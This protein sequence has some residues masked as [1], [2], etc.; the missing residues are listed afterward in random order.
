ME[1]KLMLSL[2]EYLERKP[3]YGL[4]V[5]AAFQQLL[6][7]T[8]EQYYENGMLCVQ[9]VVNTYMQ[10]WF[11]KRSWSFDK[12]DHK[13]VE[14]LKEIL[15][16]QFEYMDQNQIW[17]EK[18]NDISYSTAGQ[19]TFT[20]NTNLDESDPYKLIPKNIK[21][22]IKNTGLMNNIVGTER[23]DIARSQYENEFADGY[24]VPDVRW[25]DKANDVMVLDGKNITLAQA[26]QYL[27]S[28]SVSI[29][30][31]DYT[32]ILRKAQCWEY[33]TEALILKS[34]YIK[35]DHFISNKEDLAVAQIKDVKDTWNATNQIVN[36]NSIRIGKVSEI[37]GEMDTKK[38]D[39]S[40]VQDLLSGKASTNLSNVKM[41]ASSVS[42]YL[43]AK[44]DGTLELRTAS[45]DLKVVKWMPD[46]EYFEG[47]FVYI[48]KVV[49]AEQTVLIFM[50]TDKPGNIGK[51]PLEAS[52]KGYWYK[53]AVEF[54]ING[55]ATEEW[56]N[57]N[58]LSLSNPKPILN[59]VDMAGHEVRNASNLLEKS[60][61]SDD[62]VATNSL[63]SS[64][65]VKEQDNKVLEVLNQLAVKAE[66]ALKTMTYTGD[67]LITADGS[68]HVIAELFPDN[69]QEIPNFD[70][71]NRPP[72]DITQNET[73][74][75]YRDNGK[76][77]YCKR[78]NKQVSNNEVLVHNAEMIDVV[79]KRSND[80]K[81][82][83]II[84]S[85]YYYP[86]GGVAGVMFKEENGN[87][88][89]TLTGNIANRINVVVYYTKINETY[90]PDDKPK[91]RAWEIIKPIDLL[92]DMS[93]EK[94]QELINAAKE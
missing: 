36:N 87:I 75:N 93:N 47:T 81:L 74:T 56:V 31:T 94:Y 58:F 5:P 43:V 48:L 29:T 16:M 2:E 25:S 38:A 17:L 80:G 68:V 89:V 52:S 50:A 6:G 83:W 10:N 27:A 84:P 44:P 18:S 41:T 21:L 19:Q 15:F 53:Y 61:I 85:Y 11:S 30:G 88:M 9:R 62:V 22:M 72:I 77:V 55:A 20:F 40:Q 26:I 92:R 90:M 33:T 12:L 32:D 37:L 34:K 23:D 59:N 64:S 70:I 49:D 65:K 14:Q 86:N 1:I 78:I 76:W 69:V 28:S 71:V 35:Y 39:L 13:L 79:G 24:F 67:L 4:Q 45:G 63:W 7:L 51:N 57:N 8:K 91:Y 82:W 66:Q 73:R 3:V 46:D 60:S 42:R 54:S